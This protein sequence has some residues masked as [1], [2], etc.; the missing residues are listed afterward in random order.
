MTT[1]T[2]VANFFFFC[3]HTLDITQDVILNSL[4]CSGVIAPFC[5]RW[6]HFSSWSMHS[7]RIFNPS[8][9]DIPW[10]TRVSG[11]S[12]FLIHFKKML[13][14]TTLIAIMLAHLNLSMSLHESVANV[15]NF[16]HSLSLCIIIWTT[17]LT[18]VTSGFRVISNSWAFSSALYTAV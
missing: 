8:P 18:S 13:V 15:I 3:I 11:S 12:C 10:H 9:G 17:T 14:G 7:D 2:S 5:I 4:Y 16:S 1:L 6:C